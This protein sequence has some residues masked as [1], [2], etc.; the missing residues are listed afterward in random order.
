MQHVHVLKTSTH[1]IQPKWPRFSTPAWNPTAP[2]GLPSATFFFLYKGRLGGFKLFYTA[3]RR[4]FF[5]GNGRGRNF[6]YIFKWGQSRYN[7]H[8]L[9]SD[10]KF[11]K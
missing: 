1:K 7:H 4:F 6:F 5:L 10:G 11:F 2:P 9:K 8:D 3:Q